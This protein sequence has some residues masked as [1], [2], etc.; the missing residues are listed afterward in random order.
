MAVGV[1]TQCRWRTPCDGGVSMVDQYVLSAV[2]PHAPQHALHAHA[3][4]PCLVTTRL[5]CHCTHVALQGMVLTAAAPSEKAFTGGDLGQ[6][7]N[8]AQITANTIG[9]WCARDGIPVCLYAV[10]KSSPCAATL[11]A[12]AARAPLRIRY[13]RARATHMG[14]RLARDSKLRN[15]Y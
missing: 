5:G 12:R 4:C 9:M 11:H 3:S 14:W 10:D 6:H 13:C 8:R 2:A 15:R 7:K 1:L